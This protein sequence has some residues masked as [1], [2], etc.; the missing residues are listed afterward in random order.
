[1]HSEKRKE[2]S[3]LKNP[4]EKKSFWFHVKLKKKQNA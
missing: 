4:N 1:M 3:E 2:S